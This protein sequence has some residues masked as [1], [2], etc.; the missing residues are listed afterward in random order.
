MSVSYTKT[1]IACYIGY[2]VQAIVNNFL[3]ILFV[4]FHKQYNLNYEQLGRI[5]LI[6]YAVQFGAD[7]LTPI[8]VKRLGY[9]GAAVLCHSFVAAGFIALGISTS[10]LSNTY[11]AILASVVVFAFGS[12]IIEVIVSPIIELLPS[13]KKSASMAF[14]HSFYCWGQMLTVLLTTALVAI[15]G[16][17]SWQLIP[18]IWAAVPLFNLFLFM[19]VPIIESDEAGEFKEGKTKFFSREFICFIIFMVCAGASEIAMAEWVSAFAEQ[20]LGLSKAIGD[21][22]GP[23]AFAL[24]MGFGRVAFGTFLKNVSVRRAL[25]FNN[26]LC[27]VCYI[28]VGFCNIPALSLVACALCGFSVSLSWPGTYSMAAAR[29]PRGGTLMFSILALCGD[30]GCAIGPW[31]LGAAADAVGLKGGFLV[32][33]VFPIVMVLTAVLLFKEKDCKTM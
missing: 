26:I 1:K 12:G 28:L 2:I 9:K 14:L 23:C 30:T 10:F 4:I 24:F 6:N 8:I 16:E 25:I 29:F 31:I 22:L 33:S 5:I 3:P 11:S 27:A 32:C 15:L 19:N 18:I 21:I 13:K 7:L 20:G 17:N